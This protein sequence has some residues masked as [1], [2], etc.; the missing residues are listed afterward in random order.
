MCVCVCCYLLVF[1]TFYVRTLCQMRS[2][3]AGFHFQQFRIRAQSGFGFFSFR[4]KVDGK[5]SSGSGLGLRVKIR[6]QFR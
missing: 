5:V 4:V 1:K 3:E 6:I 2:D